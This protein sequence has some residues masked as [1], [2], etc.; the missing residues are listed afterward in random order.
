MP[1]VETTRKSLPELTKGEHARHSSHNAFLCSYLECTLSFQN[2]LDLAKHG[3]THP[4][5]HGFIQSGSKIQCDECKEEFRINHDLRVHATTRRHGAYTCKCTKTFTRSEDVQRHLSKFSS[6]IPSHPCLYCKRHRGMD[7]FRRKDHLT[8]HLRNYHHLE[9]DTKPQW[10]DLRICS[11]PECPQYRGPGFY[12]LARQE[13]RRQEPFAKVADFTRH[14]RE[15]HDESLFP[16]QVPHCSKIRGKGYFRERDLINHH[17]K[18]HPE[19]PPYS[20]SER[21]I[22]YACQE[23]NCDK[24]RTHD[25][26]YREYLIGHYRSHGYDRVEAV[27]K[28]F[29]PISTAGS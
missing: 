2:S 4:V 22:I 3:S 20:S 1:P 24:A 17:K 16:C 13:Q 18:A 15:L 14:M 26:E 29:E 28:A 11:H 6:K 9:L 8:Q 23:L 21:K 5:D 19:A 27:Q 12:L 10:M 7:G 25:F